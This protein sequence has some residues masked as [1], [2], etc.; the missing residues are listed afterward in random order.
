MLL[1]LEDR[2]REPARGRASAARGPNAEDQERRAGT[3]AG[4]RRKV[5]HLHRTR[6]KSRMALRLLDPLVR[7]PARRP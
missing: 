7:L 4:K 6:P 3:Q 1:N 2:V 5:K